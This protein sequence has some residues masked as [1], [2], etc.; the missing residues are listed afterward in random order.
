MDKEKKS[1]KEKSKPL[2]SGAYDISEI[3]T[4]P[5]KRKTSVP[6]EEIAEAIKN[7]KSFVLKPGISKGTLWH[8]QKRLAEKFNVKVRVE[9]VAG[10]EQ[11][12]LLPEG[13]Q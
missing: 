8:A 2:K 12:V 9:K 13:A 7:G 6:Y 1:E 10:T 4:A 3:K 11:F 5:L